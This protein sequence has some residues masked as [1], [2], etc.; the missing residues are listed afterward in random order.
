M[1]YRQMTIDIEELKNLKHSAMLAE[2]SYRELK[3]GQLSPGAF[4]SRWDNFHKRANPQTVLALLSQIESLQTE[5]S[6][7]DSTIG[8]ISNALSHAERECAM[9]RNKAGEL[10]NENRRLRLDLEEVR[11]DAERLEWVSVNLMSSKWN[12]IVDSGSKTQWFIRGD[13]RYT[14]Q[15]LIGHDLRSAI[16]AARQQKG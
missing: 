11:K 14:M 8:I 2:E 5:L 7:R 6:R 1:G 13:Y 10:E 3:N 9:Y 16:D 4:D 15:Q 12:G